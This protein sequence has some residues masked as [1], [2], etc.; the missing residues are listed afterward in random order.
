MYIA[1]IFGGMLLF[2]TLEWENI[3][4]IANF[5]IFDKLLSMFFY[6]VNLRT[7]G[8]V[9]ID[10]N[11]LTDSSI[12]LSTIF[13]VIGAGVG[14]TGGGIKVTVFALIALS[15]WHS[16]K[17]HESVYVFKRTI[18]QKTIMQA[19]TTVFVATFYI[20]IST[21]LLSETQDDPFLKI[22][23][24]VV[25]AFATVGVSTGNGGVLSLSANFN[26]FGKINIIILM[27]AGRIGILAFT[28]VLVGKIVSQRY[29]YAEGRVMI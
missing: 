12:F 25:S 5:S 15:M 19:I 7:A 27:L 8:F 22:L 20:I 9:S 16:L 10:L 3:K 6:S 2:S 29:K 14:G 21:V 28:I 24:E 1:L 18:P 26:D 11:T 13:M 23:Y 4:G 17:G